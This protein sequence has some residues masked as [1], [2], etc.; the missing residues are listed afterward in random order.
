MILKGTAFV[1]GDNINTD[2]ILPARYLNTSDPTELAA[3]CMEDLDS[4][5]LK[6]VK[7]GDIVVAGENFGC[8]SSREHAPVSIKAAGISI[9]IAK[10]F[11]RIFY[12][13]AFNVGLPILECPQVEGVGTG[14]LLEVDIDTGLIRNQTKKR[15]FQAK[16]IPPF[17]K[18]I[19][20]S[21]GLMRWVKKRKLTR[22]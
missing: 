2:V 14:D 11:A 13:N 3:H 9:V 17:M 1:Y 12:I 15:D 5:F 21:G 19:L 8:G 22:T 6:K 18:E 16:P 10:S 4:S 7:T 20:E